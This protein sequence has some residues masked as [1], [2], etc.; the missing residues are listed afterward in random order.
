MRRRCDELDMLFHLKHSP[1]EV[2]QGRVDGVMD[3]PLLRNVSRH[4]VH[5]DDD[6]CRDDVGS[7]VVCERTVSVGH[8]L[9]E[10]LIVF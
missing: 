9:Q 6:R 3:V 5:E 10:L 1:W 8:F 7:H 4:V 2:C